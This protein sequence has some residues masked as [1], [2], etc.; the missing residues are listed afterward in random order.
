MPTDWHEVSLNST[1]S[2]AVVDPRRRLRWCLGSFVFLLIFIWC[3][4]AQLEFTQGAAFREAALRPNRRQKP[5]AAARGRILARDGTVLACDREVAAVAVE[6]RYLE[7]PPRES[8]LERLARKRLPREHRRNA[9]RLAEEVRSVRQQRDE[10]HQR[11]AMLCGFDPPEWRAR[12]RRIQE[13]VQR[14][15]ANA[16]LHQIEAAQATP[17]REDAAWSELLLATSRDIL[18]PARDIVPENVTVAEEL[19][20]HVVVE[21][22]SAAVVEEIE[23]HAEKY[24]G[25]RIRRLI[26]RTYPSGKLAAHVLGYLGQP[27]NDKQASNEEQRRTKPE[28]LLVGRTGAEQQCEKWLRGQSGIRVEITNHSGHMQQ[29]RDEV[30]PIAGR[31]VILTIDPRLQSTAEDLLD[32]A[33]Q[34]VELQSTSHLPA[35]GAVLLI[36]VHSGEILVAASSPRFEPAVFV[37]SDSLRR[38][39]LLASPSHPLFHRA[40]QM[41]L[42]P[43]SVFKTVAAAAMV[44]SDGLDPAAAF[45]CQGYLK[46]P[47]RQRCAIYVRRG[48]GHGDVTL[49]EA[50]AESCNVYF[51]HH[52]EKLPPQILVDWARRFG[53]GQPTGVDL[54]GEA[55]GAVPAPSSIHRLEGHDWRAA[56]TQA[57]SIGQGSLTATPLQVARMMAAIANGGLLVAPHVVRPE[58]PPNGLPTLQPVPGLSYSTL[59]AI[60][61]GLRQAVTSTDGT[62]HD[63]L[64]IPQ[65]SVAGK[66]GTAVI[67]EGQPEH[68]WFAGYLPAEQPQY[69]MV[70]VLER[71]GNASTAAC[72]VA[73]RLVLRMLET[74]VLGGQSTAGIE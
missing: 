64:D 57:M 7:D 3:R 37:D 31:D 72:P 36:D 21:D 45:C 16:R 56:D 71:G 55:S 60:R 35:G 4:A 14:I 2:P 47:D 49:T 34:R 51:F 28:D 58:R 48:T 8:W 50:L 67:M 41:A 19:A 5:L 43:G 61:A 54:P 32:S 13:H 73:K 27:I 26:R 74:G 53:F 23:R 24:P 52:A 17:V 11:L 63:S 62:A 46:Q 38:E 12:A 9:A 10:L 68:A 20:D 15:A 69:A 40:I 30:K 66:T 59:V 44:E 42:P 6:Y 33:L 22:V 29:S 25:A 65:V 1:E 18:G 39:A 70:V